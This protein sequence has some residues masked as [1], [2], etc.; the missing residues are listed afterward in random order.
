M[1]RSRTR[2]QELPIETSWRMVEGEHDSFDTSLVPPDEILDEDIVLSS[3][4]SQLSNLSNLSQ[5]S[6]LSSQSNGDWHI[7]GSQDTS[8]IHDFISKA[9]EERVIMRSPFEPSVPGAVR[10]SPRAHNE[11][12]GSRSPEP[13]FYMPKIDVDSPRRTSSAGSA[14]TV[15]PG[16][17]QNIRQRRN[18][19]RNSSKAKRSA[20]KSLFA[21]S[22]SSPTMGERLSS[23][24]P[25]GIYNILSWCF[26]VLGMALRFAQKPLAIGLALYLVF[27]GLILASNWL[28]HSF[29]AALSPICN[30][31]GLTHLVDIPF[32]PNTPGGARDRTRPIEFDS[33]MSV[34][35]A[36]EQVY[37]KS[38]TG[39]SLPLEMKRSETAIRDLR[40]MVKFSKMQGKEELV[41]HF[42]DFIDAASRASD[43]LQSFN[44]HVGSAVDSVISL[45]RW[46]ARYL[47]GLDAAEKASQGLIT[48]IVAKVFSPFQPAVYSENTLAEKY[49]EVT[50][51]LSDKIDD[52][53]KEAT[54]VRGTLVSAQGHLNIINEWVYRTRGDVEGMKKGQIWEL[55]LT[56]VGANSGRKRTISEHLKLLD[57]VDS[58]RNTALARVT[59]LIRDLQIM[60][61]ELEQLR[62]ATAAPASLGEPQ[63][64]PLTIDYHID[65]INA[66]VER[67]QTARRRIREIEND[68]VKEALIRGKEAQ[69]Q[70]GAS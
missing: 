40:S 49:V 11:N 51:M 16:D 61:L 52:L 46:T 55:L 54:V 5:L 9:D 7:G 23:D 66:G 32:C 21:D 42:T 41:E 4:P 63:S 43:D 60:K 3:G 12:T 29:Y 26:G 20:P 27:G 37:E 69:R 65:T 47:N 10:R 14:R 53:I 34:E 57:E 6:Q 28:T 48:N 64:G 25:H 2:R 22:A 70:I 45:N 24:I 58:Q 30:I 67:L 56:L 19:G 13:Q 8:T 38:A 31:P 50:A 17:E 39:V 36:F 33:L 1:S 62:D 18:A 59:E 35:A 68:R 15:R 44:V